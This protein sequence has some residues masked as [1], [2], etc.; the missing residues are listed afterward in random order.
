MTTDPNLACV[1]LLRGF[2]GNDHGLVAEVFSTH[3]PAELLPAMS[4]LAA[5]YIA[6]DTEFETPFDALDSLERHLISQARSN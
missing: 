4:S 3:D 6:N 5:A 2:F 1:E